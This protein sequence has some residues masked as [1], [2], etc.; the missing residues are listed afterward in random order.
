MLRKVHAL[1]LK[2]DDSVLI[3][4]NHSYPSEAIR[5]QVQQITKPSQLASSNK[6]QQ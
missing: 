4:E 2:V 6:Y 5:R 1:T 3:T